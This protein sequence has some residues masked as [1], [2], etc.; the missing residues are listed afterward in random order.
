MS[1]FIY[2]TG[3]QLHILYS[4]PQNL[5]NPLIFLH[6]HICIL[7]KCT[8]RNTCNTYSTSFFTISSLFY[9]LQKN[10]FFT[11][12]DC[13]ESIPYLTFFQYNNILLRINTKI[14][15]TIPEIQHNLQFLP[16][17]QIMPWFPLLS[18]NHSQYFSF[19][20]VCHVQSLLSRLCHALF[21]LTY[22][23]LIF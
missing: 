6:S 16:Q 12:T 1:F 10:I 14:C 20:L 15:N 21:Y 17:P 22:Y 18:I 11:I 3:N 2:S 9:T 19:N 7:G 5:H 23:S 13:L 4:P 8:I